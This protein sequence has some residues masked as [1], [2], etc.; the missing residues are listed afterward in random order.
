MTSPSASDLCWVIGVTPKE[1]VPTVCAAVGMEIEKARE[2]AKIHLGDEQLAWEM[3]E[4]AIQRT[5]DHLACLAAVNV[6]ETRVIL[7]RFYRNEVRR[8]R[9][10]SRKL[11][12]HGSAMDIERLSSSCHHSYACVE[13]ELDLEA[14]LN[15][16][17]DE[18]RH[19][20]LLRYGSRSQWSEVAEVL[21]KSKE[22]TRKLCE[23]E[24][25]RIRK[26]LEI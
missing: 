25:K 18:L 22:A 14:L 4:L 5:A 11:I 12:Y 19:A 21:S 17:P 24:L 16:A 1:I 3:M 23:R 9:R 10:A 20:M 8:R 26:K 15:G 7:M 13:A 2:T 6:E